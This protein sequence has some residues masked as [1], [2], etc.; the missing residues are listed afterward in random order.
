M[1]VVLKKVIHIS[2]SL[3]MP[4]NTNLTHTVIL[5]PLSYGLYNI[6][7]ARLSYSSADGE[8]ETVRCECIII[9]TLQYSQC[10]IY[11]SKST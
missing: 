6:S 3:T 1:Y 11:S 2:R 4:S 5:R 7:W 10:I 8:Q 9:K